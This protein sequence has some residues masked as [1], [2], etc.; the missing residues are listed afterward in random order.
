M[1]SSSKGRVWGWI[2]A[3]SVIAELLVFTAAA[4][5]NVTPEHEWNVAVSK[6]CSQSS[7]R[8]S[9]NN[10]FCGRA[11]NGNKTGYYYDEEPN[12]NC[13]HTSDTETTN[14]WSVDLGLG[15]YIHKIIIYARVTFPK[16]MEN[17]SVILNGIEYC[18]TGASEG[19]ARISFDSPQ[20]VRYIQLTRIGQDQE[21]AILNFCELE[22]YSC[23]F[24]RWG[25]SCETKCGTGCPH[26]VPSHIQCDRITGAC[27]G[28]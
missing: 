13:Q 19:D 15:I 11:L 27:S 4:P 8:S 12:S 28:N 9:K 24:T 1:C 3:L 16:R 26:S 6:S 21:T 10:G 22:A 20:K 18:N 5:V 7:H 17:I 23:N 2:A 14:W 25:E